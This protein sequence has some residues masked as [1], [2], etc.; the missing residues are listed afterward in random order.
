MHLTFLGVGQYKRSYQ[1]SKSSDSP[2]YSTIYLQTIL[3]IFKN[4]QRADSAGETYQ[5]AWQS[6]NDVFIKLDYK[7]NCWEDCIALFVAFLIDNN[8]PESTIITYTSGIKVVFRDDGVEIDDNSL[9]LASFLRACKYNSNSQ[10]NMRLPIG[11][12]LLRMLS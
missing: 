9:L 3:E 11:H 4:N 6:F 1:S 2:K 10:V 5:L 7:P 12:G 8:N